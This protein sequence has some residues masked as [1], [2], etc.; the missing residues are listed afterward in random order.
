VKQA[1][2]IVAGCV[3]LLLA[4]A[5]CTVT[6]EQRISK[7]IRAEYSVDQPQFRVEM[8]HLLGPPLVEGN[9]IDVLQNGDEIFPAMLAA[10]RSARQTIAIEQYIWSPGK[11]SEQFIE[12]VVERARAGVRVHIVVDG[13]GSIKLRSVDRQK[14][15]DAGVQFARFNPPRWFRLFK[16]NHRTHRKI[17]VVDGT[18]AF[19]GGVCIADEWLGNAERPDRWREIHFRIK[20]PIVAQ[21]QA[22]FMDN[23]LET[24][25]ELL[26]GR[27]YINASSGAGEAVAQFFK[28][29]PTDA[30]EN[31]RL[32]YLLAIA[33]ARKSIRLAHAYFVPGDVAIETF[34][35][36]R[37]RGVK[38]EIIVPSKTDA[39]IVGQASRS[40]WPRLLEAGV[41]FYE[42]QPGLYHPKIM[43]VDDVWVTAGSVNFDERSFTMNDEANLNVLDR[44]FAQRLVRVFEQDK[45]KCRHLTA[46]DFN[47]RPWLVR[48]WEGFVGLFHS[49][50]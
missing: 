25:S 4:C 28:S 39:E 42:Y 50:L 44:E 31:A 19:T 2:G 49:Q 46:K 36:A 1:G 33:A 22:V 7:P 45:S 9:Q 16:V 10:I 41:E 5:G 34:V 38:V 32:S 21:A 30:A 47:R 24:R 14:L 18:V 15:F 48:C 17:M 37:Q 29:G 23:W 40:R 11:V 6:S 43:I 3:W 35:A 27:E 26:Q 12:A 13:L 20:G 8:T